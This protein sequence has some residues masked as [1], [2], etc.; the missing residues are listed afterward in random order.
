MDDT[1]H[2]LSDNLERPEFNTEVFGDLMSMA[3]DYQ[4]RL[5]LEQLT[6]EINK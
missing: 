1:L 6:E 4:N 2:Y 3:T 5:I